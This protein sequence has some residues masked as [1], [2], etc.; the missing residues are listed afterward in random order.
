MESDDMALI[1]NAMLC[2]GVTG[3][4]LAYLTFYLERWVCPWKPNR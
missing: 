1:F 2:I 3:A 4:M